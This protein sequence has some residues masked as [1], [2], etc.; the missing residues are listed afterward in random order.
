VDTNTDFQTLSDVARKLVI[1]KS[2]ASRRVKQC[3][4]LGYLVNEEVIKGKPMRLCM[5]EPLPEEVRVLPLPEE[6]QDFLQNGAIQLSPNPEPRHV[7][8][9]EDFPAV[10]I[11]ND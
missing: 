4:K 2:S 7:K 9:E 6:L 5:G 1:D 11:A 3:I 8:E 10:W